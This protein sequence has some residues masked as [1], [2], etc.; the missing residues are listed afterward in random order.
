MT[1]V[2]NSSYVMEHFYVD[3]GKAVRELGLPQTPIDIAVRDSVEWF[4]ANGYA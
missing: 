2:K 4:R 1:T 3:A